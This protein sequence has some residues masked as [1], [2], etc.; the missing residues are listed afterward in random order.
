MHLLPFLQVVLKVR[1]IQLAS[2]PRDYRSMLGRACLVSHQFLC[3]LVLSWFLILRIFFRSFV[4]ERIWVSWVLLVV[5]FF[6]S[7]RLFLFLSSP[8]I[9]CLER[10]FSFMR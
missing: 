5:G 8:K 1:S 10:K 3:R 4:V 9:Y 7:C 6:R 2:L